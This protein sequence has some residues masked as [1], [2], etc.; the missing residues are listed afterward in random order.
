[1][2]LYV[3]AANILRPRPPGVPTRGSNNKQTYATRKSSLDGFGNAAVRLEAEIGFDLFPP[4]QPADAKPEQAVLE[5]VG[6]SLYFC[7]PRNEKLIAYWDTV[8]D[9]LFKIRN[10]LSLQGVFR[11][12]PLYEPPID[13]ALLIK[14][15]ALGL[16]IGTVLSG[17]DQPLPLVRFQVLIQKAAEICQEVKSLGNSLLS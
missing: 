12:L 16:D 11:Q 8:A 4:P 17:A 3:L 15:S 13:P 5:S 1:M 6:R 7:I 9:R 14:A 10:S 2:Q